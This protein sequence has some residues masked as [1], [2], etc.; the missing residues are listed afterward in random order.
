ME[1]TEMLRHCDAFFALQEMSID[2]WLDDIMTMLLE[3][4]LTSDGWLWRQ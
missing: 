1:S 3:C 4:G 2:V